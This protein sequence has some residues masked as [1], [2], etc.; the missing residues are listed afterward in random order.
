MAA[1]EI[2]LG[3][4]PRTMSI[5]LGSST[6]NLRFAFANVDQGGWFMDISDG[7]GVSLLCGVPLVTGADL[8]AQY[9]DLGIGGKLWVQS[10][11]ADPGKVPGYADLGVTSHL[12]FEPN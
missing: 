7:N 11:G 3:P 6:Y 1:F 2:P 4:S 10:D 12:Y 8:L 9:P 5:V